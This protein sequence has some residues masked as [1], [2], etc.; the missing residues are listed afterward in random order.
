MLCVVYVVLAMATY[1]VRCILFTRKENKCEQVMMTC[2][3]Y[4]ATEKT[5]TTHA[6]DIVMLV[7]LGIPV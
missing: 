6:Q 3:L 5:N 2:Q 1:W 4:K 7:I